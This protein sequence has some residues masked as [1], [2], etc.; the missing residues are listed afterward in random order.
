MRMDGMAPHRRGRAL[1]TGHFTTV[2][3]LEVLAQV[4]DELIRL[5]QPF[6]V[7]PFNQRLLSMNPGWVAASSL[8]PTGFSHLIVVCGPFIA[9]YMAQYRQVLEPFR[10]CTW[11]GVNLTMTAPLAEYDP[12]DRLIERDSDRAGRPD[13]SFL[14]EVPRLPVVGLCLARPQAEY[15]ERQRHD[16]AATRLRRLLAEAGV[17]VVELD[18]VVPREKNRVGIGTPAE[19]ESICARLD[20]VVTTR[21]HGTVLSLKCGVPVLAVDAIAGGGKVTQQAHVIGWD[22]VHRIDEASDAEL[23]E[24]LRRCLEPAARDTARGCADRA[25]GLLAGFPAE[26]AGALE[27]VPEPARRP[28]APPPDGRLKRLGKSLRR[29]L[30]GRRG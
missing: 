5:G 14:T 22:E 27:A 10:H 17:A 23:A 29:R 25:R 19:F 28:P 26:L 30:T 18:T 16:E 3:D 20:A 1:V 7:T 4:E 24:A 2:G 6:A 9:R 8:E 11:I 15:G 13:L 12:F 21:L